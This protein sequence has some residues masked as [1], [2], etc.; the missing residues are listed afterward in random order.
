MDALACGGLLA[1]WLRTVP[2]LLRLIRPLSFAAAAA[3]LIGIVVFPLVTGKGIGAV[4]VLKHSLPAVLST[5][6]VGLAVISFD[7]SLLNRVFSLKSLQ[8]IGQISY[9]L[10]IVHP[11]LIEVTAPMTMHVSGE[12]V[13]WMV[14]ARCSTVVAG[15]VLLSF[16]SRRFVE[17]PFLSLKRY[18]DYAGP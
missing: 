15:A 2:D 7:H 6:L 14:L 11:F 8:T 18:F 9:C 12:S 1:V 17:R 4:Q 5:S 3:T 10:Y 13:L 16:L